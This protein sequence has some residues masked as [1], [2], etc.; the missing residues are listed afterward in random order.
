MNRKSKVYFTSDWHLG[1]AKSI[2][3]DQ[4]P[5]ENLEHMHKVLI[6]N[7][8]STISKYS[9]CYFL[10]DIGY[11]NALK[12]VIPQLNSNTKIYI[13]GN[14]CKH[15]SDNFL[16]D[17]GFSAV[18]YSATIKVGQTLVTMSHCPLMGVWREDVTGMKGAEAGEPWHGANR[19]QEYSMMNLGQ[20]HLHG[21]IHSGPHRSDK[22][23]I[24]DKQFDVGVCA[25]GFKPINIRV[26]ES[27][28]AKHKNKVSEAGQ[29]LPKE[30]TNE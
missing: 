3:F 25:H 18:F 9:V 27:W 30:E 10:G 23:T 22:K 6:N 1:H 12:E 29:A 8:N 13:R 14:H 4:R 15:M 20:F 28:I 19:H 7:Y 2:E 26:I 5:F 11:K 17:C 24:L 21:H 16:Y